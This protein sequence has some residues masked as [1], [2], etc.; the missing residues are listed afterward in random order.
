M[1]FS[2]R[3]STGTIFIIALLGSISMGS[4]S[5]SCR[6]LGHI[7]ASLDKHG[8]QVEAQVEAERAFIREILK[9]RGVTNVENLTITPSQTYMVL[10]NYQGCQLL[11]NQAEVAK[12]LENPENM[13]LRNMVTF[14]LFHEGSH[15]INKDLGKFSIFM[16]GVSVVSSLIAEVMYRNI[17]R[18][19]KAISPLV[20]GLLTGITSLVVTLPLQF[21]YRKR[22]ERQADIDAALAAN[23]PTI[24][25]SGAVWLEQFGDNMKREY[26]ETLTGKLL[27]FF[28]FDWEKLPDNHVI[29]ELFHLMHPAPYRRAAYLHALA[30][31]IEGL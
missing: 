26:G 12:A 18:L 5:A 3:F 4:A 21:L 10:A 23:N 6:E 17:P 22:L 14:V 27:K 9:K 11:Y 24:I 2:S 19:Q 30:N 8:S 20:F 16:I 25:R 31:T 29:F 28:N 13:V 15:I 1:H 7:R